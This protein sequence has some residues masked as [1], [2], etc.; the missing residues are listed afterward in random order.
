MRIPLFEY[1]SY[2]Y[3][4]ND[5]DFKK[6]GLLKRINSQK[7]IRT[8]LQTFETDRQT[9]RKSYLHYFKDLIRPELNQFCQEAK[10]S[11]M[12]TDCWSV[13]YRRG[14]HQT[15]HNHRSWGFSG[16]LYVEFDPKQHLPTCFVPPWQDPISDTTILTHP[17]NIKEG[18]IIIVPSYTLH[19]VHPNQSKKQRTI[20]SFDL[21]PQLPN[22]QLVNK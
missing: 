10:V 13:R 20:I 1:P 5:W 9:S 19:F 21:L 12:M 6:K 22:H 15:I 14:D 11:C 3:E 2:K 8:S 7:F 16:V 4:V 18:T 17:Q